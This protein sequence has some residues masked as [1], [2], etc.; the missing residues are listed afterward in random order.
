MFVMKW[1]HAM[2]NGCGLFAVLRR[3]V[4]SAHSPVA[5]QLAHDGVVTSWTDSK[6]LRSD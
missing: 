6:K 1:L 4:V 2:K 5:A 3:L